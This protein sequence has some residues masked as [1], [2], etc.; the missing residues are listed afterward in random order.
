MTDQQKVYEFLKSA[1]YMVLAVTLE[2]GSPWP[3][4]VRLK[5]WSGNEFTWDSKLDTEHSKALVKNPRMAVTIFQK[6]NDSQIGVYMKGSGKL[7]EEKDD[8][9]TYV[10][11]ADELWLN[12]ETFVKRRV[13]IAS[14]KN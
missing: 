1:D 10:F 7:L 4:P 14:A 12:D 9:G 2:D 3:V 6:E 5:N 11:T 13:E 8:F